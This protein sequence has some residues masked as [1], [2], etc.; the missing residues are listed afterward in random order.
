MTQELQQTLCEHALGNYRVLM[1]M[2]S[3]LLTT[4]VQKELPELDEKLYLECFAVP[5]QPK[6]AHYASTKC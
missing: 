6:Q 4:A 3:H 2:A 5:N 1:N